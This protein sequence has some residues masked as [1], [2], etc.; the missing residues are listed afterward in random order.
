MEKE[1]TTEKID[2]AELNERIEKIVAREAE[3]R[4]QI[5]AIIADLE[6]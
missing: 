1:D 2:I 6:A 4:G 5:D 3:L